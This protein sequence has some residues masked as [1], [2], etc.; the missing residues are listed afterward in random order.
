MKYITLP[1]IALVIL[2]NTGCRKKDQPKEPTGPAPIQVTR[3]ITQI[4]RDNILYEQLGY[5]NNQQLTTFDHYEPGSDQA[6]MHMEF[7]TD[8]NGKLTGTVLY[9][10]DGANF[11]LS[12]KNVVQSSEREFK[13]TGFLYPPY[14]GGRNDTVPDAMRF[15]FDD[16]GKLIELTDTLIT[17]KG[18]DYMRQLIAITTCNYSGDQ[19]NNLTRNGYGYYASPTLPGGEETTLHT[20]SISQF[21]YDDTPNFFYALGKQ[22][23][24]L[25]FIMRPDHRLFA[26]RTNVKKITEKHLPPGGSQTEITHIFRDIRDDHDS[27]VVYTTELSIQN[28]VTSTIQWRYHYRPLP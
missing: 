3:L 25:R 8:A 13:I 27:Q 2:T 9:R 5:N 15:T 17:E 1:V 14:S 20:S 26:G 21:E 11:K 10:K 23:P 4:Y 6:T 24:Y 12:E 22:Y 18:A 7:K 19:L 16:S 28:G